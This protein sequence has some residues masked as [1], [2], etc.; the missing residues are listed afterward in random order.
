MIQGYVEN[1]KMVFQSIRMDR[2]RNI[3]SEEILRVL[4]RAAEDDKFIAQLTEFGSKALRGYD[5]SQQ[6]KAALVS[7][8]IRW[9]EAR[10]GKLNARLRIWLDCRLQQEIW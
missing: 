6:A 5:L 1:K 10:V 3:E 4:K 8:D 2:T 9:I 7:G